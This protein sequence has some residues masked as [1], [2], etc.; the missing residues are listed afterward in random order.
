M[1][2]IPH[3]IGSFDVLAFIVSYQ[4]H[5]RKG[6]LAFN[7]LAR[8]LFVIQY[9]MLSAFEG[10]MMNGIGIICAGLADNKE[11]GVLKDKE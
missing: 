4:Q 5:T 10:A 9:I 8:T 2:Y 1:R 6:I 3:I 7:I 11:K